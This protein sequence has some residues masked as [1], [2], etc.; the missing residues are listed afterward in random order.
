MIV[1]GQTWWQKQNCKRHRASFTLSQ[2]DNSAVTLLWLK[3]DCFT[4]NRK[5]SCHECVNIYLNYLLTELVNLLL[6]YFG[7]RQTILIVRGRSHAGWGHYHSFCPWRNRS[8][9]KISYRK[10]TSQF[11]SKFTTHFL[12]LIWTSSSTNVISTIACTGRD[13]KSTSTISY[14]APSTFCTQF[15]SIFK[16]LYNWAIWKGE[17][18]AV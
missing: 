15:F 12:A 1:A 18:T 10:H 8:A 4:C 6:F 7:W 16:P 14:E 5:T 13:F 17:E 9:L 2:L 11:H 3:P